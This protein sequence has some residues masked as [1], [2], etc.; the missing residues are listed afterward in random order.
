LALHLHVVDGSVL[1]VDILDDAN[2]LDSAITSKLALKIF[3][4]YIVA[5][6]TDEESVEC[7]AANLG[8]VLWPV[9]FLDTI[10]STVLSSLTTLNLLAVSCL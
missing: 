8:I 2:V 4:C 3:L 10:T 9:F 5:Q 1:F 6:S 7:V